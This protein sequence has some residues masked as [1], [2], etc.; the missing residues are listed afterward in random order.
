MSDESKCNSALNAAA[1]SQ[2]HHAHLGDIKNYTPEKLGHL[3]RG[4]IRSGAGRTEAQTQ[5]MLDK[6]PPSQ[7]AGVDGQSAAGKVKEYLKDKDASHIEPHSKGGFGHPD[8]MKWEHKSTNRARGDQPMTPQEQMQLDFKSQL[9]NLTGALKAG[10]GAIPKGAAI[11]A[12]TTAPFSMLRNALRVVRGEISPQ[13]AS[14]ETVKETGMGAAVGAGSAFAITT[15]AVACPPLA[16]AL[17]AVSPALLAA[18]GAGTIYEFFNIL[19]DHKQEVKTYYESLTQQ[20]L[21]RL[22]EIEDELLLE[23]SKNLALLDEFKKLNNAITNRPHQTGIEA[24]LQRYRESVAI[25]QSLG[26]QPID[27]KLLPST[28]NLLLPPNC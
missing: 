27:S 5:Q 8:N 18:G 15:I 19:D 1:N 13:E 12:A 21:Q 26:V 28:Q 4:G 16:V 17:A 14:I 24:A 23:H 2:V 9:D 7:R 20:E 25:A 11:G 22:Q 6:I 10:I 3:Q